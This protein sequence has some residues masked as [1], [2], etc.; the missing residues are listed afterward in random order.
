MQLNRNRDVSKFKKAYEEVS[1]LMASKI[2]PIW[3]EY[4]GVSESDASESWEFIRDSFNARIIL[5][6]YDHKFIRDFAEKFSRIILKS[7]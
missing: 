1:E 5:K 6:T 3:R 4:L 2:L 7:E